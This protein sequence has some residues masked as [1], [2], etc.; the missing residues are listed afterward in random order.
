MSKNVM[1][2]GAS[3]GIGFSCSKVFVNNGFKVFGSV[4]KAA[5]GE[6]VQKELGEN[7]TPIIFDVTDQEAVI[8]GAK[9]VQ[10]I[11]GNEG[12]ALLINNAGIAVSGPLALT[13]LDDYR[14]QF[15]VN[16]FGLIA[17]TQAFL[18]LLGAMIPA[19]HSPG[20][21]INIS[22]ASGQLGFPFLSPYVGSK[23]AVEGISQSL[24]R[25]LMMF[26]IDVII[27]G[28]GA[29]K[30][31]IWEKVEE[32]SGEVLS[33]VYGEMISKFTRQFVKESETALD[34]DVLAKNIFK[35][36]NTKKPKSRYAFMTQKFSKWIV[37]RYLLSDRALDGMIKKIFKIK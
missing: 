3:T 22:S 37:P 11:I 21:I 23:Y 15:E 31:P 27:I 17:V 1:I 5:D 13:P 12:L 36:Y 19:P 30:T 9:Q 26:G 34:V 6:K 28:P 20:K 2:T 32:P 7:F 29:V 14:K 33:S 35:V 18:P 24:R 10:E 8:Q 25:E 4:R 16:V